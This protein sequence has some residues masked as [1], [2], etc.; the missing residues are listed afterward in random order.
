[1]NI[2][3]IILTGLTVIFGLGA[4]ASFTSIESFK[5]GCP[6]NAYCFRL[7]ASETAPAE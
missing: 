1:M 5:E 7:V 4:V 3:K 6:E 2:S